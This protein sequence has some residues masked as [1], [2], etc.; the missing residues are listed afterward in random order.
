M[1]VRA[2]DESHVCGTRKLH[3]VAKDAASGQKLVVFPAK[4]GPTDEAFR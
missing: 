2:S 3:V 1:G 4:H